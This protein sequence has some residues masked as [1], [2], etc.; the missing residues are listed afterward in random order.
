KR[1]FRDA[2][3]GWAWFDA[4]DVLNVSGQFAPTAS[5]MFKRSAFEQYPAWLDGAPVGDFFL[6][7]YALTTGRGRYMPDALS[8]YRTHAMGSW[9]TGVLNGDGQ[10]LIDYA[11]QMLECL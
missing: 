6:E 3:E 1:A 7:M 2:R 5:Y 9:T 11:T 8:V 4:Q 10:E